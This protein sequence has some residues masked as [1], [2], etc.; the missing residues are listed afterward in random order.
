MWHLHPSLFMTTA[1]VWFMLLRPPRSRLTLTKNIKV[2][3]RISQL[4]YTAEN[5]KKAWLI[6]MLHGLKSPTPLTDKNQISALSVW[7]K[8]QIGVQFLY[9]QEIGFSR[10]CF[11]LSEIKFPKHMFS[12]LFPL[13]SGYIFQGIGVWVKF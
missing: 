9:V 1:M 4:N 13:W 6:W 3:F 2:L 11:C 12:P 7:C 10:G 8:L 5:S